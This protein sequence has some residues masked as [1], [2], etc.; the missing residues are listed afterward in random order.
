MHQSFCI[1]GAEQNFADAYVTLL[2]LLV[3]RKEQTTSWALN[4]LANS[5]DLAQWGNQLRSQA[6]RWQRAFTAAMILLTLTLAG[7]GYEVATHHAG[8]TP[9]PCVFL[10]P[11]FALVPQL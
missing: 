6:K 8:I 2:C 3:N 1:S 4:N 7:L 9:A 10:R 5:Q 11:P